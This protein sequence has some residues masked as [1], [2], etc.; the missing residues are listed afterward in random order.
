MVRAFLFVVFRFVLHTLLLRHRHDDL[1]VASSPTCP[2]VCLSWTFRGVSADPS[3]DLSEDLP[4]TAPKGPGPL[5]A[6]NPPQ[7]DHVFNSI[8]NTIWRGPEPGNLASR[9]AP[10][11]DAKCCCSPH[12]V[13]DLHGMLMWPTRRS[14]FVVDVFDFESLRTC[15]TFSILKCPDEISKPTSGHLTARPL[16]PDDLNKFFVELLEHEP[17]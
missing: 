3:E 5:Q 1:F 8:I 6:P 16:D 7:N 15:I 10:S 17:S 4:K 11:R 13:D 14:H 12:A 9:R 2:D